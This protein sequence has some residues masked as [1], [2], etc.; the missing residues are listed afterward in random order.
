MGKL[1]YTWPCSIAILYNRRVSITIEYCGSEYEFDPE[2]TIFKK[3]YMYE[4]SFPSLI[5]NESNTYV[6]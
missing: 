2:T 3:N 1:S 6:C 4:S 5:P